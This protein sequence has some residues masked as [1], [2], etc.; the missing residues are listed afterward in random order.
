MRKDKTQTP[1]KALLKILELQEAI[2]EHKNGSMT[3][4]F[5]FL[6]D[7]GCIIGYGS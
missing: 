7:S 2:N 4:R 5:S 3:I 6:K 1:T